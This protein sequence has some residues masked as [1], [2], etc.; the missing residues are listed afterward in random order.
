MRRPPHHAN[1]GLAMIDIPAAAAGIQQHPAAV[2]SPP[3]TP[4]RLPGRTWSRVLC[5]SG[6]AAG[7]GPERPGSGAVPFLVT[8]VTTRVCLL[9]LRPLLLYTAGDV[10]AVEAAGADPTWMVRV[11][12]FGS[13]V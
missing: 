11:Q 3:R 4:R 13:G 2:A 1:Q 12:D 10:S 8:A 9:V 5:G 7:F 6:W